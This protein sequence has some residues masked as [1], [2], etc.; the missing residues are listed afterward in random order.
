MCYS[1]E[2]GWE[3][4]DGT[5]AHPRCSMRLLLFENQTFIRCFP[6]VYKAGKV[7]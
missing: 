4:E 5:K 1:K 6:L 7:F 3:S 2:R